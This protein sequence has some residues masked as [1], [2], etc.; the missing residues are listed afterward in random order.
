MCNG[1]V[2]P[3]TLVSKILSMNV[4]VLSYAFNQCNS[5]LPSFDC[6]GHIDSIRNLIYHENFIKP[7]SDE[8]TLVYLLTKS[9]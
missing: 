4:N 9:F 8:H 7:Y 1:T 5:Y 2:V 6:N 3:G